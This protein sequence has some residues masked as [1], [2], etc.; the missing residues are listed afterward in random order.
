VAG[1]SFG[2]GYLVIHSDE[3]SNE[4]R[5]YAGG[6][7]V[8]VQVDDAAAEHARL[9][10]LGVPVS[11]LIDQPWGMRTFTVTD[12]DGYAWAFGQSMQGS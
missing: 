12:P 2:T 9:K 11:D 4:D 5:R 10:A 7:H 3:R 1:L 6:M 8:L